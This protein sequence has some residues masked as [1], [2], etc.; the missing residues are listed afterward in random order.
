VLTA[1][2]GSY[3]LTGIVIPDWWN[4][5]FEPYIVAATKLD[6]ET[7]VKVSGSDFYPSAGVT[8]YLD[9]LLTPIDFEVCFFEDFETETSWTYENPVEYLG[10]GWSRYTYDSDDIRYNLAIPQC[11]EQPLDEIC[12]PADE[13]C[14]ICDDPDDNRCIPAAAAIPTP[15]SGASYAWFGNDHQDDAAGGNFMGSGG[16]CTS[17]SGS[18]TGNGG[19]SVLNDMEGNLWS[20]PIVVPTT[21]PHIQMSAWFEIESVDPHKPPAGYDHLVVAVV[22]PNGNETV[23]GSLNS[24]I[25]LDGRP[26]QNYASGGFGKAPVWNVYRYELDGFEGQT[27]QLKFRLWSKDEKYNGFRGWGIDDIYVY[28]TGGGGCPN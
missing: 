14:V 5:S 25:D 23:I 20:P 15:W 27:V 10:V 28:T 16:S 22:Q 24:Q 12:N 9:F 7:D 26:G 17:G 4:P 18:F 13:G 8:V 21:E 19:W 6:F 2:D 11:S 1:D 3:C